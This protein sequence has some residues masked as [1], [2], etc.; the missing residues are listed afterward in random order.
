M[1][2][3]QGYLGSM[4]GL[5][6]PKILGDGLGIYLQR[7]EPWTGKLLEGVG[8]KS[9]PFCAIFQHTPLCS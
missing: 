5:E 9:Q 8:G 6:L 2:G 3:A 7:E 4:P 1:Q